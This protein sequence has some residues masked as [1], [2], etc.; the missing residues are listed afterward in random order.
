MEDILGSF[1]RLLQ[2]GG[3]ELG[4]FGGGFGAV[5]G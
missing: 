1:S 2:S 4:D 5:V 3:G